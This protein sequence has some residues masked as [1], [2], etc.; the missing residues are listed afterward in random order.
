MTW[1]NVPCAKIALYCLVCYDIFDDEM[2]FSVLCINS[3]SL[4]HVINEHYAV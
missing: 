1:P 3:Q 2:I 4:S